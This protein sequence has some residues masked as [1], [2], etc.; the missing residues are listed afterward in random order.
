M[1]FPPHSSTRRKNPSLFH[2]ANFSERILP[3]SRLMKNIAEI[4]LATFLGLEKGFGAA[5]E[6]FGSGFTRSKWP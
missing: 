6:R 5:D 4:V 1:N 3:S 2:V